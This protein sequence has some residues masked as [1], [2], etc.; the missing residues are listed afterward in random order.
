MECEAIPPF[1]EYTYAFYLI[2]SL[3]K[4]VI[5]SINYSAKL[6]V[7]SGRTV[8]KSSEV[9]FKYFKLPTRSSPVN[10]VHKNCQRKIPFDLFRFYMLYNMLSALLTAES[11]KMSKVH[12]KISL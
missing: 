3:L 2:C 5:K 10:Y 1:T 11:P 9:C 7:V 4:I 6:N 8:E 12:K